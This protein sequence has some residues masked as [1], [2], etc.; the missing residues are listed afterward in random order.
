VAAGVASQLMAYII[1]S[2]FAGRLGRDGQAIEELPEKN[3]GS[4]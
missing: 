4:A 3:I 1:V 2:Y